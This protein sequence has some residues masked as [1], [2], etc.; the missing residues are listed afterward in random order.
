MLRVLVPAVLIGAIVAAGCTRHY[1]A[2]GLVLRVEP[3]AAARD[4]ARLTISHDAIPRYMDAMV[5]PFDLRDDNATAAAIAPGDRVRFR[6]NVR[7]NRSWIDRLALL[8]APRTDAGLLSS[9]ARAVLTPIGG[10]PPDFTLVDHRGNPVTPATLRGQTVVVTFIYTRCPLPDYC[11]RML[12]NFK[13][14][15]AQFRERLGRDLTLAVITFDPAFDTSDVLAAYARAHAADR[16]GWLFL[17]GSPREVANVCDA[18]GIERWPDAGLL[19]HTL[20]TAVLDRQGRLA[21]TI[22]GRDYPSRQ[23][24]D[25]IASVLDR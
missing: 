22:E 2:R 24:A 16:P 23:L 4:A 6:L 12:A 7:G 13:A 20:Q 17:T 3:P 19:T 5:M 25:L 9:P 15:A 1:A 11:P 14:V 21:G 18:F 8:S 10:T